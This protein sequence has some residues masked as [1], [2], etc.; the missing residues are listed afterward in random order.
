MAGGCAGADLAFNSGRGRKEAVMDSPDVR[1][2]RMQSDIAHLRSLLRGTLLGLV[3][4]AVLTAAGGFYAY[5]T[6]TSGLEQE[7]AFTAA[8]L[9][10]E[11]PLNDHMP[12]GPQA[13]PAPGESE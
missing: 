13:E 10:A 11:P 2:A 4:L 1:L 3:V 8:R 5:A 9:P 12:P 7:K 6:L